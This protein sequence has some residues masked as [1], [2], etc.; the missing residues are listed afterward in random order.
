MG[1]LDRPST[2]RGSLPSTTFCSPLYLL[3]SLVYL[4]KIS[5]K[6]L[7]ISTLKFID[8]CKWA[9]YLQKTLSSFGLQVEFGILVIYY[10]CSF[11]FTNPVLSISGRTFELW[12]FGSLASTI[13]IFVV[14]LRIALEIKT[15]NWISAAGILLSVVVYIL[16][17][18]V[19]NAN[20][21]FSVPLLEVFFL[22]L[23]TP[24]FYLMLLNLTVMC[25]VPD[26][27]IKYLSRQYFPEDW[28]ILREKYRS[29]D[30]VELKLE[31]FQK[32][33]SA[34]SSSRPSPLNGGG[35]SGVAGG[36]TISVQHQP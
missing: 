6:T 20:S 9:N 7:S 31:N 19:Y 11:L 24:M 27:A 18:V 28:Q 16:F 26:F 23:S 29:H 17:M 32:Q 36:A 10:G 13:V 4:R 21:F 8:V 22:L 3:S 12:E 14:N 33:H 5:T 15:W 1:S 2:T 34:H 35:Y 30:L 25:L